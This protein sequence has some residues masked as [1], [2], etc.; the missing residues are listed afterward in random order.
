MKVREDTVSTDP[1]GRVDD[2]GTVYVR[3]AE[4]ER[5]VG[6]WQAGE[7]EE[8]LAYFRRKFD[9][10][11]GQVTLL[12][13]RV[14]GTDL[15]PAQAEATV[16]KLRESITD[17]HAVGDL[18]SL[19]KRLDALT[20]L[21]GQ[22]REEVKAAREVARAEAKAVKERI[23][24]EAES[25]AEST[26]HWKTGGERLRQLVEEWKAAERIDRVTE[27]A[28]WK[29][30]SAARTAFAKRRKVYFAGLDEQREGIRSAKERIVAEAEALA[31]STDWG[32]TA[33][34][35]RELMR[36]W[37][38]AGR[39]S[40]EV[41][42]ELWN[43]FKAAQDQ[44]FQARSAVFAERDASFAA[45]AEVKE[46]LLTEAE[47]ILPVTDARAAR[48]ALRGILERWEEAGPVPREQRDRLEGGLRKVDDAVRKAEEAEWK[49][50]NPEAR[51][52]AQNTVDQLRKSIEQLE[53]R[54]AKASAAGK[55]KD[56]KDAE[57]ALTA[58]RSWLEEAERTLAEFS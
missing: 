37:K 16:A 12:E 7:P 1:W 36:Q 45:N 14:R 48:A 40:R 43:R 57:E 54:L 19:L 18:D 2:D 21:V 50:S 23:V 3:T 47:R 30:L 32:A 20:E 22:R 41:E 49:R 31:S 8:A 4:G 5:A 55:D 29:R 17:A 6:S 28:L 51:A 13:Q 26:T 25:V 27:A 46:R 35:Y 9:E 42:D 11:A 34:A 24:A 10:L 33:S 53:A 58:R 38:T 44:F 15:A 52:R 56:V 39:A